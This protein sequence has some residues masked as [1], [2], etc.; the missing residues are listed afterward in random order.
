MELYSI[1]SPFKMQPIEVNDS[2]IFDTA[3]QKASR[4]DFLNGATPM[5]YEHR[6]VHFS[7]SFRK[8]INN[9]L[10]KIACLDSPSNHARHFS[11]MKQRTLN[12][13][14]PLNNSPE[15]KLSRKIG[16]RMRHPKIALTRKHQSKLRAFSINSEF[17]D[18]ISI[19]SREVSESRHD[20]DFNKDCEYFRS[21]SNVQSTRLDTPGFITKANTCDNQT[22]N[23]NGTTE[24]RNTSSYTISS[25]DRGESGLCFQRVNLSKVSRHDQSFIPNNQGS[26]FDEPSDCNPFFKSNKSVDQQSKMPNFKLRNLRKVLGS[27]HRRIESVINHFDPIRL[28]QKRVVIN[29]TNCLLNK[30]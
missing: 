11:M 30:H 10:R 19:F 23:R 17:D 4:L 24:T 26:I 1:N 2:S 27:R 8:K 22:E 29:R 5:N 20:T 16:S 6:Q 15:K 9:S 13:D 14:T 12:C 25:K 18:G 28:H 3:S 7:N 21:N